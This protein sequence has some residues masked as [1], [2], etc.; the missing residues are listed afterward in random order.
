MSGASLKVTYI[1]LYRNVYHFVVE[2]VKKVMKLLAFIF[3]QPSCFN[4]FGFKLCLVT[5]TQYTLNKYCGILIQKTKSRPLGGPMGDRVINV[6]K[7]F[8]EK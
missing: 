5:E 1:T 6:K 7:H 4:I 3:E 8:F 2:Y